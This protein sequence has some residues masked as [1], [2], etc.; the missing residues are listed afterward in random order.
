[1]LEIVILIF[2]TLL[3]DL[4]KTLNQLN[5]SQLFL[6]QQQRD[7]IKFNV[8]LAMGDEIIDWEKSTIS[9]EVCVSRFFQLK[10]LTN[11][12]PN[13]NFTV[14]EEIHGCTSL[15]KVAAYSDS[16]YYLWLDPDIIFDSCT[17]FYMLN[18]IDALENEGITKFVITPEIVKQWDDTWD[19]L[20]NERFIHE[21]AGYQ[22]KNNPYQDSQF[23][24]NLNPSLLEVRNNVIGQPYMKFGGGWFTIL[25]KELLNEI[26]FPENYGHYGVDDTYIMWGAEMLANPNIKQFKLKDVIVCENYFDRITSYKDQIVFIDRRQEYLKINEELLLIEMQKFRQKAWSK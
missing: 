18:S 15:R 21:P 6:S 14:S 22:A 23:D 25:S 16:K 5:E 1:M 9:K 26:P 4:E 17:L 11:W 10:N 8:V 3:D 7:N 24:H 19:C 12:S 13:N 2:P 20:V